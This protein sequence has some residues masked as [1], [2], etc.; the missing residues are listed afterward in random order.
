MKRYF[1]PAIIAIFLAI[2]FSYTAGSLPAQDKPPHDPGGPAAD[3]D[4]NQPAADMKKFEN[5]RY[6]ISIEK[7]DDAVWK[8]RNKEGE[9][10]V[11]RLVK[12]SSPTASPN[13]ERPLID[14]Y[15]DA[16]NEDLVFNVDGDQIA[17]S[18]LKQFAESIYK[19]MTT[20]DFTD[21]KDEKKP[22][23]C[24]KYKFIKKGYDFTFTG[25]SVAG[26]AGCDV[27]KI[28]AKTEGTYVW[29]IS[30]I[31]CA[32]E[33]EKTEKEIDK[34]LKSLTIEDPKKKKDKDKK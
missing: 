11:T 30:V 2:G 27:W 19:T 25:R 7:P 20:K 28:I 23:E 31:G 32:G 16:Y 34:I 1:I 13:K 3:P 29:V 15:L 33:I 5:A 6:G 17:I 24:K 14:I 9:Y 18:S 22:K 10:G 4:A 12:M 21:I 8:F 26:K